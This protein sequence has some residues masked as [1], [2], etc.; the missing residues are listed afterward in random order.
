[1]PL[2]YRPVQLF[3]NP[4]PASQVE[5][6]E[7]LRKT[8]G[9]SGPVLEDVLR[10]THRM[11]GSNDASLRSIAS[12]L[13]TRQ[14]LRI[15]RRLQKFSSEDAHSAIQKASLSRFLPA[16]A[17]ESL[18]KELER[19]GITASDRPANWDLQ[20]GVEEGQLTIG[21]T[22]APVFQPASGGKV[23]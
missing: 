22:S 19:L 18:E 17:K 12:N 3:F 15:A 14:L 5:E 9:T 10:A 8:A 21:S 7:V 1:M 11:R 20:C 6:A 16:L 4:T 2:A 13:S 23:S